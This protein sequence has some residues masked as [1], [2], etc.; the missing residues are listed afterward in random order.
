MEFN[1]AVLQ[2]ELQLQLQM[3]MDL[4]IIQI[5]AIMKSNCSCTA[6]ILDQYPKSNILLNFPCDV[7]ECSIGLFCPSTGFLYLDFGNKINRFIC[8][9]CI[10]YKHPLHV[11][12]ACTAESHTPPPP[13]PSMSIRQPKSTN[14]SRILCAN[15]SSGNVDKIICV[16]TTH[17]VSAQASLAWREN[18][19]RITQRI[20]AC[21]WHCS[22]WFQKYQKMLV[23]APG[24]ALLR[25]MWMPFFE[26]SCLNGSFSNDD[27]EMMMIL[28]GVSKWKVARC[29]I[30]PVTCLC[31]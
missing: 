31:T 22:H 19:M 16:Y 12:S 27:D 5:N 7:D 30:D 20:R 23:P 8:W 21:E 1:W 14:L 26:E 6:F 9:M 28:C 24:R 15:K 25:F 3:I 11:H 4:I 18:K 10:V 2:S 29:W 13:L 17:S